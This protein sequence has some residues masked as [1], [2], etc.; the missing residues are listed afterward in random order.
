MGRVARYAV[1]RNFRDW[2]VASAI[3]VLNRFEDQD[4]G[5]F[6]E[7]PERFNENGLQDD[8][9]R[10]SS[11]TARTCMAFQPATIPGVSSA[12]A[13]PTMAWSR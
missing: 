2:V 8:S 12:S 11:G 13:P 3:R 9:G 10:C 5:A 4:T 1:A 7:R 6:A